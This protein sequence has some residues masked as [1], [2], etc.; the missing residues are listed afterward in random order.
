MP[1]HQSCPHISHACTSVAGPYQIIFF[2]ASMRC[3]SSERLIS[4]GAVARLLHSCARPAEEKPS[5]VISGRR[6]FIELRI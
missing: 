2:V 1:A 3:A 6:Q 4:D 5:A